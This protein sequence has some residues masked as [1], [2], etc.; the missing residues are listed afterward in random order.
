MAHDKNIR[1]E[2]KK[3][4]KS[5]NSKDPPITIIDKKENPWLRKYFKMD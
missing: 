3:I 1:K 4:K 2:K 5:K